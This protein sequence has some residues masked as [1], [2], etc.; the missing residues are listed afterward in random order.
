MKVVINVCYGGFGVSEAVYKELG[1]EWDGY[2]YLM[3]AELGDKGDELR[4]N[5]RLIAAIEKVGLREASGKWAELSIVDLPDD[6]KKWYIDDYDGV[7]S[8][9]EAHR[10]W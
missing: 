3:G 6:L 5:P 9:H 2:G 10:S 4:S 1:L 8:I 7:E